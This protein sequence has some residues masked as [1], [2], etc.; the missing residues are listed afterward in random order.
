MFL[1][2]WAT[3]IGFAPLCCNSTFHISVQLRSHFHKN[4]HEQSV[5]DHWK[6]AASHIVQ[7][8]HA[9]TKESRTRLT[10]LYSLTSCQSQH[11][12]N[13]QHWL[14]HWSD[15]F[16]LIDLAQVSE[17]RWEMN[18][19]EQQEQAWCVRHWWTWR[20]FSAALFSTNLI[21]LY[22]ESA[23]VPHC[24]ADWNIAI[25]FYLS[26]RYDL[27]GAHSGTRKIK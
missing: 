7:A 11:R 22:F 5:L 25:L 9:G 17:P 1:N 19:G 8:L 3:F 4:N 16:L 18:G 20:G 2:F 21:F 27:N 23:F 24:H 6:A 10:W 26:H 12:V 14:H 13:G 15:G